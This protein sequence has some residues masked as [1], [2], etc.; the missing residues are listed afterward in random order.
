MMYVTFPLKKRPK[1]YDRK[2]NDSLNQQNLQKQKQ[3]FGPKSEQNE[4]K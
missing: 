4:S 3:K 1:R 2:H